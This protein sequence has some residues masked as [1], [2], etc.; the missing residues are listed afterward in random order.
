MIVPPMTSPRRL[1]YEQ[2]AVYRGHLII[3]YIHSEI[4]HIPIYAYRLLS[5]LGNYSEWH[6]AINPA[7]LHSSRVDGILEIARE[8][9]DAKVCPIPSMDYFKQ[10]YIY[11]QNL[12]VIS[13]IAG[14]FFYDHYPPTRLNNISA[15]KI[16]T[17]ERACINWV[18]AGLDRNLQK[19]AYTM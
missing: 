12:I 1:L 14:K 6:R 9:L 5:D 16:F 15:P 11:K 18:K 3:P 4:T 10:R 8:H 17:S 2:S 13:E 19:S 7:G